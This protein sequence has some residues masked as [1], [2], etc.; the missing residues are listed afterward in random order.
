MSTMDDWGVV[1]TSDKKKNKTHWFGEDEEEDVKDCW[2]QDL[3]TE[4]NKISPQK[5]VKGNV[6]EN[7]SAKLR[8][9]IND[10]V[11]FSSDTS[12]DESNVTDA[13]TQIPTDFDVLKN[14]IQLKINECE[15]NDNYVE[16]VKRLVPSMCSY[17]G[18][19]QLKRVHNLL[20]NLQL[21]K[22]KTEKNKIFKNSNK[23]K[24][25]LRVDCEIDITNYDV[26]DDFYD[27]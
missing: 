2:E 4:N 18:P 17:L 15:K 27:Y 11:E 5:F 16:F 24:A 22:S 23:K 21:E 19:S 12:H 8:E 6:S 14:E 9:N 7:Q 25:Q 1:P 20:G 3:E 13:D 26:S 10:E